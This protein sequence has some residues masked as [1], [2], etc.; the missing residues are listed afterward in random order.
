MSFIFQEASQKMKKF[1]VDQTVHSFF[2]SNSTLNYI[3]DSAKNGVLFYVSPIHT[4]QI[5]SLVCA[6]FAVYYD[7]LKLRVD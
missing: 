6:L 5:E 1:F 7:A 2:F 3:I 4:S